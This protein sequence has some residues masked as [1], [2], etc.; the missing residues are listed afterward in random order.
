MYFVHLFTGSAAASDDSVVVEVVDA[1]CDDKVPKAKPT[2]GRRMRNVFAK[3]IPRALGLIPPKGKE[4]KAEPEEEIS[5]IVEVE[6]A[7]G[8]GKY[9]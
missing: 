8:N 9:Y 5:A 6:D 2:A 7:V 3:H 4:A 1:V